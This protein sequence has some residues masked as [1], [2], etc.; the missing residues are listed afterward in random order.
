MTTLLLLAVAGVALTEAHRA[1]RQERR[2]NGPDGRSRGSSLASLAALG[3][4]ARRTGIT[5]PAPPF[6][7]SHLLDRAGRPA[8]IDAATIVDSR[9]GAVIVF[10][11]P[12]AAA[13]LMLGRMTG[14][15]AAAASLLFGWLY[16]DLWLRAAAKRRSDMVERSAP[17]ALDLIAAT[18]GAGVALDDAVAAASKAVGGPLGEELERTRRTLGLGSRRADELRNLA[19]RT[20]SPSLARLASALRISERLGVPLADNLRRQAARA[21]VDR[22][23]RV[24]EQAANAAPRILLVVVFL[25][26]PAALIPVMTALGLAAAGAAGSFL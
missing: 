5:L 20:G 10:G 22:S 6:D 24:Q 1:L 16:P 2:L 17:L 12:A 25:L 23:R 7:R 18:V 15:L 14:F 19:E 4:L 11:L 3:R 13:L 26:V 9:L 21:R 8:G